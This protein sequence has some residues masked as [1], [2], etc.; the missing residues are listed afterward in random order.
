MSREQKEGHN[1]KIHTIPLH[2][3]DLIQDTYHLDATEFGAY[4][5][6]LLIHYQMPEGIPEDKLQRYANVPNRKWASV[7]KTIEPFFDIETVDNSVDKKGKNGSNVVVWKQKRVL[8]T[9][10]LILQKSQMASDKA[11]KRWKT[12]NAN[13]MPEESSSNAVGDAIHKPE[14]KNIYIF[15]GK[16]IFEESESNPEWFS[17]Q[18]IKLL[19]F[20]FKFLY[21]EYGTGTEDDLHNWF[22]SIEKNAR[23]NVTFFDL[24]RMLKKANK[25]D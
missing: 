23:D 8:E 24:E 18:R 6:L 20:Q 1:M 9:S 7:K 13:A 19:K 21:R 22:N 25:K 2:I 11:L 17:G 10:G 16:N 14:S 12:D 15:D 5:R 3:G 4:M